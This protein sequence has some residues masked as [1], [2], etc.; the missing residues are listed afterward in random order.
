MVYLFYRREME[1]P[2]MTRLGYRLTTSAESTRASMG[3]ILES[4]TMYQMVGKDGAGRIL[5]WS[6]ASRQLFVCKRSEKAVEALSREAGPSLQ[7][8]L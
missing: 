7:P 1:G 6:R 5:L 8:L 2:A 3:S 4:P